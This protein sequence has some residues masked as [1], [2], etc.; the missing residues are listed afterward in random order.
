MEPYNDKFSAFWKSIIRLHGLLT[1]F[2]FEGKLEE[3]EE[4]LE[5]HDAVISRKTTEIER[6]VDKYQK[7]IEAEVA[8]NS[9]YGKWLEN[10]LQG[11]F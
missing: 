9:R 11:M 8:Q 1:K 7:K 3:L 5:K 10:E 6:K 4:D 2:E